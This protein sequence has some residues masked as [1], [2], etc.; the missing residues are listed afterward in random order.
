[1]LVRMSR[2]GAWFSLEIY[3]FLGLLLLNYLHSRAQYGQKARPQPLA[4]PLDRI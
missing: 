2:Y 3:F 4:A 1:M